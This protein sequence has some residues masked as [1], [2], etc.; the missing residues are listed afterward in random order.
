M[1]RDF[2]GWPLLRQLGD[3]RLARGA[4]VESDHSRNLRPRTV[5]ADKVVDLAKQNQF[6]QIVSLVPADQ[7]GPL[8]DII[9]EAFVQSTRNTFVVGAIACGIASLLALLIRNPK[10]V[11]ITASA[12]VAAPDSVE[13]AEGAIADG[14]AYPA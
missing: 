10:T 8:M 12:P 13:R 6:P 7:L 11:Q 2:L 1:A 14:T 4:A 9:K 5:T 3:D